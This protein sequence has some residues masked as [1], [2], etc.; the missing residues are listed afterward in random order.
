M[1]VRTRTSRDLVQIERLSVTQSETGGQIRVFSAA[2]RGSRPTSV[3]CRIQ[4]LG[5]REHVEFGV[6]GSRI[7]WKFLFADDPQI[8]VED[9][10]IFTDSDGQTHTARVLE[11]SRNLDMQNRIYRV[12]AEMSE[13]DQ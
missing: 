6:R 8:T 1:S 10:L 11:P 2:N 5:A 7:A 12:V 4:P 3:R 13:N 9:R